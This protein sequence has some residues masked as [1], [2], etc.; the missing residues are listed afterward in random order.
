MKTIEYLKL[1][2][3]SQEKLLMILNKQA[4]RTHLVEHDLFTLES[5]QIWVEAKLQVD[6]TLGC[7]VRAIVCDG[8]LVGWCGIQQENSDY[9]LAVVLDDSAWGVGKRVFQDMLVWA[10]ALN[11]E[12]VIIHL[13]GTRPV[14]KFLEKMALDVSKTQMMGQSF[15]SYR[16]AIA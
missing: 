9:E 14:Y 13:L 6:A 15:V 10:N 11:H 8:V 1:N 5:L 3:V 4:I 12:T 2:E 7:K 16:L